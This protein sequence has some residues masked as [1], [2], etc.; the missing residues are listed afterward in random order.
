[1]LSDFLQKQLSES[2][3]PH[4]CLHIAESVSAGC[5]TMQAY[6]MNLPCFGTVGLVFDSDGNCP[7]VGW[8]IPNH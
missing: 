6:Q 3:N 8:Y 4:S 2:L 1:M 5:F 7:I